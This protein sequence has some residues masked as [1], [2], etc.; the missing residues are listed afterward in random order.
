MRRRS[1]LSGVAGLA[2]VAASGHRVLASAAD[3]P[4]PPTARVEPVTETFFGRSVT[5]P[6]RWMETPTDPDWEPYMRG[7]AAHARAILDAIPGREALAVRISG[8][9]GS[10]ANAGAPT[11]AGGR[12]F[13]QK[14]E[15]GKDTAALF[16]REHLDAADRVLVDPDSLKAGGTHVSLDWWSAS[17]DGRH[18]VY[19]LSPAG[20]ENS[21]L[22]IMVVDTGE[23]LPERIDRTQY[24]SPFWLPDGSGFLYIRLAGAAPGSREY[25]LDSV[26]WLH[27]LNTPADDDVRILQRGQYADVPSDPTDFPFVVIDPSSDHVLVAMIGGV[28]RENPL[29]TA[30]LDDLLAGQPKWQPVATVADEVINFAFKGDDLWLLTTKDADNGKLLRTR[31]SEPDLVG[32]VVVMPQGD[33][34]IENLGAAADALYVTQLDGGYQT[35]FRSQ[36]GGA[37]EPIPLPFEGSIQQLSVT[38]D[39]PGAYLRLTSWLEP[40]GVWHLDADGRVTDTGL[41]PKPDIDTTPY[42]LTRDFAVARD[43]T[44]VPVSIISKKGAPRDGSNPTMVEAYGAYQSV[45]SPGFD[46]RGIAFLEKGGV[47]AVAHV[48]GGGEYGKRWW[49][50]GRKLTKPNTWRDLIDVCEHLVAQ[51]WT[52]PAKLGAIGGSAGGITMGRALTERPDLFALVVP[53][54]GCLNTLRIEFSQNGPPNIEEF[55]TVTTEE[56]F[57]GLYEMDSLHHVVD[58]TRYPA[59]LLTHGM[60]DPRVEPWNSGKMAARLRAAASTDSGP[61]L[62]RVDF[63]AGH[64]LGSTR[65]QQD[66]ETA[67]VYAF[68]L[69]RTNHPEFA[70]A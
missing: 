31:M 26:C 42:E 17:P 13:Y 27:R 18:V 61:I 40:S 48:R 51:G 69:Q 57:R 20:S 62:L 37:L 65:T 32:A 64:G 11:V 66:Q 28:R 52:S 9:T 29:W 34:V 46:T 10:N 67:D 49:R 45:S 35:L 68:F 56:G 1:F 36:D 50:A 12:L 33:L 39:Q 22:Q 59:V 25:Y 53:A 23:I 7:N 41:A 54:V 43:G 21:V 8:L 30:R 14:R 2:L 6:Y 5:D 3:G 16:V 38:T 24:A 55:G 63:D 70:P 47:Q 44:R 4:V 58:G 60:T 15:E 19:G